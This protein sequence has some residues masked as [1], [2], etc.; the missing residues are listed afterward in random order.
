MR[1][2]KNISVLLYTFLAILYCNFIKG[3]K[4]FTIIMSHISYKQT[5]KN[6]VYMNAFKTHFLYYSLL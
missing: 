4:V 3:V 5:S 1:K 2:M 6:D